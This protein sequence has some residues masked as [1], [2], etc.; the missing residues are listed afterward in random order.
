[1]FIVAW[2]LFQ[3]SANIPHDWAHPLWFEMALAIAAN[4]QPSITLDTEAT[5]NALTRLLAYGGVFWIGARLGRNSDNAAFMLKSFVAASCLYAVYGFL[6]FFSGND[7]ILW[8]DKWAYPNDLT[9]TF[10]NR[11]TYA[12]FAGLGLIASVALVPQL[13]G[14]GLRGHHTQRAMLLNLA[15]RAFSQAW[16]PLLTIIVTAFALLLSHS[17]GGLFS[18]G[19]GLFILFLS[20]A[21]T[22]VVSRKLGIYLAPLFGLFIIG[23]YAMAGDGVDARLAETSLTSSP[24]HELYSI[25]LRAIPSNPYLGTGYGTFEQAFMPYKTFALTFAGWDK[26]HNSYLELAFEIGIPA[27]IAIVGI[28]FW[29]VG[30]FIFGLVRRRRRRVFAAMGLSITALVGVHALFDF[31]LQI[32]GFT[33]CY[34]MLASIAWA[35]SW[36]TP[37][38]ATER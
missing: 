30:V 12:T 37:R 28:F 29:L 34:V 7:T 1:M 15:D 3:T 21:Y 27:T 20:F 9:S 14:T 16:L 23:T 31:S 13:L 6:V 24:R 11:N 17:R 26:A 22:K 33:V 8:F 32:P 35:Q 4:G 2:I 38:H 10:V 19:V 5:L 18:T 25:I 36:P